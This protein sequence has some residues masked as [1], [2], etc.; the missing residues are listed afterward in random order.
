[1]PWLVGGYKRSGEIQGL[2]QFTT[3]QLVIAVVYT[4]VR[5]S[6]FLS[7]SRL[8]QT[9]QSFIVM[10]LPS[11]SAHHDVTSFVAALHAH[12]TIFCFRPC[13]IGTFPF[14][15]YCCWLLLVVAPVAH[16]HLPLTLHHTQ[17]PTKRIILSTWVVEA[18]QTRRGRGKRPRRLASFE[19][20]RCRSM[21]NL[22]MH[23]LCIATRCMMLVGGQGAC[24]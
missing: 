21:H 11:K 22:R 14:L 19:W 8:R 18:P 6:V 2:E 7:C 20:Q 10:F 17:G 15:C 5:P 3:S 24:T 16:T 23:G 9:S 13:S 12:P 4:W 1:M